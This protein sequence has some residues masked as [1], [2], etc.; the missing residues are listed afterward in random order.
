MHEIKNLFHYIYFAKRNKF[1]LANL[2]IYII[3]MNKFEGTTIF[4]GGCPT[5]S[6]INI[7]KATF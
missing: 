3:T 6:K 7:L 2:I 4:I 5:F 1:F